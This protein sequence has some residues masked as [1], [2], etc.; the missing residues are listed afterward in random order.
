MT[1]TLVV[2]DMQEEFETAFDPNVVIGVTKEIINTMQKGGAIVFL[3]YL[4]CGSVHEG[5]YDLVRNYDK[6]SFVIKED[7]DGSEELLREIEIRDFNDQWLRV[8]GVN[9]NCCVYE[10]IDGI[11]G[12]SCHTHVDIVKS[13]CGTYDPEFFW[14]EN[15]FGNPNCSV[16]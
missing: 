7:N 5:F 4:N 1:A 13:A 6:K 16:V 10:T 12:K 9:S 14:Q 3:E 15:H 2:V 8:C 11:L